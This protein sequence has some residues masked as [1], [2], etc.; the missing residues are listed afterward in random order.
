MRCYICLKR[1]HQPI[2]QTAFATGLSLSLVREYAALI[3]ELDLTDET[4]TDL[5]PKLETTGS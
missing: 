2:E 5:L 1:A 4:L 3:E